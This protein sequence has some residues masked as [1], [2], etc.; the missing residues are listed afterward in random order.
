LLGLALVFA[1]S[2][3]WSLV[4]LGQRGELTAYLERFRQQ[5]RQHQFKGIKTLNLAQAHDL[6]QQG[7]LFVDARLPEEYAELH[8]P[9][10]LNLPPK[11]VPHLKSN[12]PLKAAADRQIVVYCSQE[13]CDNALKVAE[14]LQEMGF[15]QVAAFLG[16]FRAWDE[17]GFPVDTHR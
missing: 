13:S 1:L 2:Q 8:I 14:V 16:G 17:A 7:A 5:R 3:H 10:A 9:Q 11:Q 12:N 4:L 15:S 6:W